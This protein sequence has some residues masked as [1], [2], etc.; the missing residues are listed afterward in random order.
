MTKLKLYFKLALACR[1]PFVLLADKRYKPVSEL[2][3]ALIITA[4]KKAWKKIAYQIDYHDC[5]DAAD[6]VKA[7]ASKKAENGVGRVY[8][9]WRGHGLHYWT[10]ALKETGVE[11]IE[12]QT[13]GRNLKWGEYIPFV[14]MI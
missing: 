8:G 1:T 9:Y 4:G 7:E 13:A 6:I 12:P 11:M 5:D 14:V 10:V 2:S 3:L